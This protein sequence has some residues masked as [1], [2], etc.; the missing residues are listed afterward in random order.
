MFYSCRVLFLCNIIKTTIKCKKV[1][2]NSQDLFASNKTEVYTFRSRSVYMYSVIVFLA[3]KVI[4]TSSSEVKWRV[5]FLNSCVFVTLYYFLRLLLILSA[6]QTCQRSSTRIHTLSSQKI[7][8]INTIL[9]LRSG[10]F[11]CVRKTH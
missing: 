6:G 9:E 3:F 8:R 2:T 7:C 11:Y 4:S 1:E 5:M 10:D